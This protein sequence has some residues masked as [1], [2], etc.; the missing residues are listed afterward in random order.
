MAV[1]FITGKTVSGKT[2][3]IIDQIIMASKT[4]DSKRILIIVPEQSTLEVQHQMIKKDPSHCIMAVEILS[5]G[6]LAHRM[7]DELGIAGKTVISDVGKNMMIRHLINDQPKSYPF[8]SKHIHKKGY[9]NE[10][11]NL[12]SE[13]SRYTIQDKDFD[14][15]FSKVD[16][17]L[18]KYKLNDCRNLYRDY[19]DATLKTYQSGDT[20]MEQLLQVCDGSSFLKNADIY[21]DGF[22]GFTP[23]Q[24]SLI[25]KFMTLSKNV[26][27]TLTIDEQSRKKMSLLQ[28]DIY[29]ES[30]ETY[31]RLTHIIS[32]H[33]DLE[34]D[35]KYLTKKLTY[36]SYNALRDQLFRYPYVAFDGDS[37]GILI[38]SASSPKK[39]VA[40]V[41]DRIL[42][43]VMNGDYRYNEIAVLVGDV[44]T[45]E[46]LVG[47]AFG[48]AQIPVYIDKKKAF[49]SNGVASFVLGIVKMI[50]KNM[51]YNE[52]FD[53]IKSGYIPY[54]LETLDYLENYVIA[55]GIRGKSKWDKP[56][57]Y[58]V[59]DLHMDKDEDL[60][61]SRLL[62][63]N[64]LRESIITP[65]KAYMN[66]KTTSIKDH[67]KALYDFL[68]EIKLESMVT[69]KSQTYAN[70]GFIELSKEYDQVYGM[71]MDMLDQL[72]EIG[73]EDQVSRA[74]FCTL[75]GAGL[76]QLE[77][78]SVPARLDEVLVGDLTRTF[79]SDKKAVFIL[80]VNE[81]VVP[82]LKE[83]AGLLTDRERDLMEGKGFVLAPSAK[84]SLF[85]DQFY[86]YLKLFKATKELCISYTLMDGE[87]QITRPA[88]LIHS[89]K[90]ILPM[91]RQIHV[92][93]VYTDTL[94]INHKEVVF[95]EV[96][97]KM[98][99]NDR[100]I[101]APLIDWFKS[102]DTY[103]GRFEKALLGKNH[104]LRDDLLS[105]KVSRELYG[106]TLLNSISRLEQFSKC[107]FSHFARY[108]LNA[109]ERVA[110]D[111]TMPQLGLIFHRVIELFSKRV[112][113]RGIKWE[114]ITN[115]IREAW[116]SE[117]VDTALTVEENIVFFDSKRNEYRIGRLKDILKTTIYAIGHQISQGTFEP[118][119]ME[120]HFGGEDTD[121]EALNLPL[122]GGKTMCLKGTIDRVDMVKTKDYN[123]L[124]I[125]DYK[126]SNQDFDL[127][128]IY[129]GLSLQLMVYLNA[130]VEV[131]SK[132]MNAEVKPAGVFYF[133][134][135]DPFIECKQGIDEEHIRGEVLNK[136]R[137]RGVVL[138]NEEVIANLDRYF[139][140][141][142][143]V[144]PVK[145]NNNGQLSKNSKVI[146]EEDLLTVRNYVKDVTIELGNGIVSGQMKPLPF[147]KK[148]QKACDFCEFKSVC[149]FDDKLPTHQYKQLDGYVEDSYIDL[150]IKATKG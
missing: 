127:G 67:V 33:N 122:K 79:I 119:S 11:R 129:N 135:D 29:F 32:E 25:E 30:F 94:K 126:S 136:F 65:I 15:L 117:L 102:S 97:D 106:K 112:I 6:R 43:M 100:Q 26:T 130:A 99:D 20:L 108:G 8:L 107:P 52:T 46:K 144:I 19:T 118:V 73:L 115:A 133:K 61:L 57:V 121:T 75:L 71:L 58:K 142:S 13:F 85:R 76:E 53:Y 66:V 87:G 78:G 116:V 91:V 31:K 83:G 48:K 69:L 42:D 21:I 35:Y 36:D 141:A 90:K 134:I 132:D 3:H 114:D 27:M 88:H 148:E 128:D 140:K 120:W 45:Y 41:R 150:M 146:T 104:H 92:D 147:K 10:L 86:V 40:Y 68:Q 101:E 60:A 39:E 123:Y 80:G 24:Y 47:N 34:V 49:L 28:S 143:S 4:K 109:N 14:Q 138:D 96:I 89:V 137:L 81:G 63:I 38:A 55:Y 51:P 105:E 54:E 64:N 125:V 103:A 98:K 59:P 22:Y 124:T 77:L 7:S 72:Y 12:L 149:G 93:D 70:K 23:I 145:R 95:S 44:T 131:T 5:F 111:I 62:E 56:W 84:K 50:S 16:A 37:E 113:Q 18:L 82:K 2:N 1:H 9:I 139:S 74:D 110:Y 17:S